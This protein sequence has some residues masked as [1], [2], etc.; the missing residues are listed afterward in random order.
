MKLARNGVSRGSRGVPKHARVMQLGNEG[1]VEGSATRRCSITHRRLIPRQARDDGAFLP[2][3]GYRWY[4]ARMALPGYLRKAPPPS[5]RRLPKDDG[6][7]MESLSRLGAELARATT[8]GG[9]EWVRT[10]SDPPG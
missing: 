4:H 5:V 7:F 8:E 10:E 9:K 2:S 3:N 6:S 1:E